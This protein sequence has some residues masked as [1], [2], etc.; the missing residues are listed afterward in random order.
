MIRKIND[1][2]PAG[3][4]KWPTLVRGI[5][6]KRYKRFLADVK[7][8]SGRRHHPRTQ[9][10]QD[11]GMVKIFVMKPLMFTQF[12]FLALGIRFQVSVFRICDW[13]YFS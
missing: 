11:T 13:V 7:L 10:S 8:D 2:D 9:T 5:L 6:I 12:L 4:L 1:A 3:V